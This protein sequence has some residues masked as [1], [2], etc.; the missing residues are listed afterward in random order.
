MF[1]VILMTSE[2]LSFDGQRPAFQPSSSVAQRG[3]NTPFV[4]FGKSSRRVARTREAAASLFQCPS[5][6]GS[7]GFLRISC[8]S[9]FNETPADL[10]L[11][12][13]LQQALNSNPVSVSSAESPLLTT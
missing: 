5:L 4:D 3:L 12:S 9:F 6:F 8:L 2:R 13:L 1:L 10:S 11:F 7:V